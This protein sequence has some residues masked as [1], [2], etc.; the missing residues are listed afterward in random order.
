MPRRREVP[1]RDILPHSKFGS[2]DLAVHE[3]IMLSAKV[4]RRYCL[5]CFEQIATKTGK[6]PLEVFAT[7][8]NNAKP[9]VEA[10]PP[11]V[12]PTIKFQRSP[13]IA[14]HGIGN[15]AIESEAAK[16][17]GETHGFAFGW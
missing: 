15:D 3:L 2:V 4:G 13:S 10:V 6:D 7:A 8:L 9:M 17:R 1:K 14:S 11:L 12:A 5:R 16:K